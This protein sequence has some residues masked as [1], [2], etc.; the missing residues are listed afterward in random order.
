[1]SFL[2]FRSGG[3]DAAP[4]EFEFAKRPERVAREEGRRVRV[5]DMPDSG[6]ITHRP[7][8][9]I[10]AEA[11]AKFGTAEFV[12]SRN[13]KMSLRETLQARRKSA[14]ERVNSERSKGVGT[15]RPTLM[16]RGA[17]PAS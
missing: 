14:L 3:E 12:T 15:S 2:C 8:D 7:L 1:M 6:V 16:I 13:A 17:T 5:T 4:D 11:E 10:K 9:D